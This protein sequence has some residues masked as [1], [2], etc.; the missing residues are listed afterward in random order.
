[1][2]P[3]TV[4]R[5]LEAGVHFGH[6]TQRWNPKMRKFIY[7]ERNGIYIINLEITL[8]C[9]E[10]ALKFLKEM[11]AAG[12]EILWVGT[13]K[14]AQEIVREYAT[15]CGM[16]YVNQRWL[17]GMLTNYETVRKSIQRLENI[18]KMEQ[19]GSFQF[20]TKKEVSHLH[21]EREKL[22][23]ILAGI[24]EMQR[25]PGAV[26]V[27]DSKKEEIAIREA[28]KLNIPIVA[29]LDTNSDP[30]LIAYPLPGNDDAM[31][32]LKLFCELVQVA[33]SE[34]RSEYQKLTGEGSSVQGEEISEADGVS[35]N[36]G[37]PSGD[38]EADDTSEESK[39]AVKTAGSS[40]EAMGGAGE[41]PKKAAH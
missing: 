30:D 34:G 22:K 7:G 33:I 32:S 29:V 40:T 12:K 21:K 20:I 13:K 8:A 31:R 35:K 4:K 24:R 27:I 18:D 23:K 39:L 9:L 6:Q 2:P 19:E 41:K 17:G 38:C 37:T 36:A 10:K 15:G 14:Q 16:P 25:L 26:F 28:A 11:A 1:M 3:V 5:L